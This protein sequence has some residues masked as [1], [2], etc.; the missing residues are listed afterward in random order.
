MLRD[1]FILMDGLMEGPVKGKF[2]KKEKQTHKVDILKAEKTVN[3]ALRKAN[4]VYQSVQFYFKL[5]VECSWI[6]WSFV[7]FRS[8]YLSLLT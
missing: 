3:F 8:V 7:I 2:L 5:Q 6:G 1:E 4:C